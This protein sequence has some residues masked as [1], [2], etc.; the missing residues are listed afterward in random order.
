MVSRN[1]TTSK[2]MNG[3]DQIIATDSLLTSK[4]DGHCKL[5]LPDMEGHKVKPLSLVTLIRDTCNSP[6]TANRTALKVKRNGEWISWTYPQ[7]YHDIQC[8]SRAFIKLGL[9]PRHTVAIWGFNSP[10]WFISQMAGIFAGGMVSI[11]CDI[12]CNIPQFSIPAKNNT[13]EI[14]DYSL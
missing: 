2:M 9:K 3:P 6:D 14:F 7:Y 13:N 11:I 8:L 10:E 5:R 1:H 4:A 12:G